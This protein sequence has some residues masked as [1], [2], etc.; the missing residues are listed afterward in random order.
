M[1]AQ[2]CSDSNCRGGVG[3]MIEPV[4]KVCKKVRFLNL[5]PKDKLASIQKNSVFARKFCLL[6]VLVSRPALFLQN[7]LT[8]MCFLFL[9]P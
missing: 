7:C 1:V 9:H 2:S 4:V 6:G 8:V 5:L 3:R